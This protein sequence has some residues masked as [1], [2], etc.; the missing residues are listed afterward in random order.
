ME[1]ARLA[2]AEQV[3]RLR[4]L[5]DRALRCWDCEQPNVD[6]IKYRENAVFSVRTGEG[7]RWVL[8][9]HRP[10]YR[11]DEAIRSEF[12]WMQAL[13]A[14]G[15]HTPRVLTTRDGDL[16]TVT[17]GEGVPEARQCDVMLWIDGSPPGSLEYGVSDAAAVRDLYRTV[18]ELAARMHEH[19][20]AWTRPLSFV[21]P[22]WDIEALIGDRPTFGRFW[23][24]DG[25][26]DLPRQVLLAA[27]DRARERLRDLGDCTLLVHG[28]LVP[29]N[30]L[31]D[32]AHVRVIDFDDCG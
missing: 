1:F 19:G 30:L 23:E 10:R 17:Q 12:A 32:G 16:L 20:A 27:R 25:L 5:A 22:T 11:S 21:R 13:Q 14:S 26:D 7:E 31:V 15:I 2:E 9:V 4:Q 24:L 18:G 6:L 8:R 3:A 29:D 28:D